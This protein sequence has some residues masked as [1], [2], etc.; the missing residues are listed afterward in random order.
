MSG[1]EMI[2][3]PV[4]EI[5]YIEILDHI[6]YYHTESKTYSVYGTLTSGRKGTSF[7]FVCPLQPLLPCQS[8][9]GDFLKKG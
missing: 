6:L 2:V 4:A 7:F 5:T 9:P 1:S 8:G 3:L